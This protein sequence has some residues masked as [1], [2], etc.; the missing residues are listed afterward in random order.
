MM[1]T[2]HEVYNAHVYLFQTR[3]VMVGQHVGTL[4]PVP[5]HHM[6]IYMYVWVCVCA[7]ERVC[8]CARARE[9][10][11]VCVCHVEPL[12]PVPGHH[13]FLEQIQALLARGLVAS[14]RHRRQRQ[15]VLLD[16][17]VELVANHLRVCVWV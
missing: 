3:Y 7:R 4:P 9:R 1:I 12:P 14:Q 2:R 10:V 8:V 6:Y 5:G 16:P 17:L 15:G 11:C 13:I